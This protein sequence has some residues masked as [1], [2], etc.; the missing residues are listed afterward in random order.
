[1]AAFLDGTF[2][3]DSSLPAERE[4]ALQLG[5]TR[6]TLREALQRLARDG[7][8][9]IRQGK[10]TRVRNYW[11]EGNLAVLAAISRRSQDMPTNFVP[12]LLSVRVLL[13]PAYTR[14]AIERSAKCITT[15]LVTAPPSSA[16]V[17]VF[18]NFDWQV[19]HQLTICSGN[20][21]FTLILNGFQ[22][23]Y[24]EMGKLYFSIP[25]TRS[26]SQDFYGKLLA[27][28][29]TGDADGA[30]TL[31]QKVMMD[32]LGFWNRLAEVSSTAKP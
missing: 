10:P 32:S 23:L 25:E 12:D 18:S 21:V 28:S 6:P 13:A 26:S 9:E 8:V 16:S 11:Q 19:H 30:F 4:L 5:V 14:L 27:C 22:D 20:P 3:V 17:E 24:I 29:R 31:T 1:V 7:W 15:L 2:P